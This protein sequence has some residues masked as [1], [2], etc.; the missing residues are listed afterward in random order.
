MPLEKYYKR[1][2]FLPSGIVI[3]AA[4]L[5]MVYDLSLGPGKNYKS[6]WMTADSMDLYLIVLF[7]YLT[8]PGGLFQCRR[9]GSLHLYPGAYTSL[10]YLP[11]HY[12]H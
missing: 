6:E 4:I 3:V 10:H 7:T 11:H 5:Y 8:S 9:R 1:A 2:V 12:I